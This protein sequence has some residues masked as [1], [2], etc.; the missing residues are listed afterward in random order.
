MAASPDTK[1]YV[2]THTDFKPVVR[3]PVYETVDSRLINGDRCENG[4]RGSFYS[5]LFHYKHIAE[6]FDLP[7][8]VGVCGYRKYFSFMDKVPDIAAALREHDAIAA[9][10]IALGCKL[11]DHYAYYHNVQDLDIVT[12]IIAK[13]YQELLP[14]YRKSLTLPIMYAY[15][16]FIV[17]REDFLDMIQTI[18]SIIDE[19]LMVVGMDIDGRIEE[20]PKAYHIGEMPFLTQKYQYRIGG[21]LGE[22]ITNAMLRHRFPKIKHYKAI[23]TQNAIRL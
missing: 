20:N 2:C 13:H 15:N 8:Y 21:L 10:P 16:M 5:E 9:T 23:V 11:R 7:K 3:N 17:R 1:I 14:D 18:Y 19:Y 22:R 12:D 6:H 4:L